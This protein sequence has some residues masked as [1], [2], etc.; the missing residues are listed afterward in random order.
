MT[1]PDTHVPDFGE[2]RK[3]RLRQMAACKRHVAKSQIGLLKK[4]EVWTT[5][6]NVGSIAPPSCAVF[7]KANREIHLHRI[8]QRGRQKPQQSASSVCRTQGR[9]LWKG[10]VFSGYESSSACSENNLFQML[11]GPQCAIQNM[12]VL[13]IFKKFKSQMRNLVSFANL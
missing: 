2:D 6:N 4:G 13:F 3:R 10:T 7:P 1:I 11:F 9:E 12:N 8:K 5:V